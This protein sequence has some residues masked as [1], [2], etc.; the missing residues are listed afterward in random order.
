A[1]AGFQSLL[2][3][4]RAPK[5]V[6]LIIARCKSP[7]QWLWELDYPAGSRVF[8][9]DKCNRGLE[10]FRA[11]TSGLEGIV[12]LEYRQVA[13]VS[14]VIMTGE[15]TAYLAHLAAGIRTADFTIFLHDDAPRHIRMPLLSMVLR[16]LRAGTYEVPFL[17]LAHERY[18]SYRTPCLKEVHR[19]AL[20]VEL[21]D[22]LG[23]YCCSHFVVRRDRIEAH[24]P[25]FYQH[26][27]DMVS[28]ATYG[29]DRG[30]ACRVGSKPC[31]V[32]EFLWHVVFGEPGELPPR[33]E[34]GRLPLALRY[35]GGRASR[36]P[37]PLRLAPYMELF[38]ASRYSMKLLQQ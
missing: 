21:P 33:E 31:Y 19:Q 27:G 38:H 16:A 17:H 13:E 20:R 7:L 14:E 5:T 23:T 12:S 36:M 11:Q 35:E 3:A 1:W 28:Q 30:G 4:P 25:E 29:S 24:D 32:M 15:C 22:R 10:E 34:D 9:Y 6:D 26:L 8:V 18:P 2:Q 37:S